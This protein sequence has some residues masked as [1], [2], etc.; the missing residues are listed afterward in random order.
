MLQNYMHSKYPGDGQSLP[1]LITELSKFGRGAAS[2]V[3]MAMKEHTSC[4]DTLVLN[5]AS[6]RHSRQPDCSRCVLAL[7]H[8]ASR[9]G[10]GLQIIRTLQGPDDG[11]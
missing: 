3:S 6:L 10:A 2:C 1:A 5:R 11:I 7:P 9:A 4:R 8:A